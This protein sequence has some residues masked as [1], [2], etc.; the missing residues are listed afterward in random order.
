MLVSRDDKTLGLGNILRIVNSE[1]LVLYSKGQRTKDPSYSLPKESSCAL[2][3]KVFSHCHKKG[4]R[5]GQL[6]LS[7]I[8]PQIFEGF[9]TPSTDPGKYKVTSGSHCIILKGGK[10]GTNGTSVTFTTS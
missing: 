3:S 6:S 9:F 4:G 5:R 1:K 2:G 8:N 7:Y 10:I